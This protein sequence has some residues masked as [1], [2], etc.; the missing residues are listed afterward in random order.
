MLMIRLS[1]APKSPV[2]T[3]PSQSTYRCSIGSS[4][5][6]RACTSANWSGVADG[7]R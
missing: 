5:P 2:T 6:S 3:P 1:D 4:S 7:P